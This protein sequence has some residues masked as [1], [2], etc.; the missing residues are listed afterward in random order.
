M[1]SPPFF[2]PLVYSRATSSERFF[3]CICQ[4]VL[5][6]KES[7]SWLI[8]SSSWT[9]NLGCT[10]PGYILEIQHSCWLKLLDLHRPRLKAYRRFRYPG[11]KRCYTFSIVGKTI[12][13][14]SLQIELTSRCRSQRALGMI[15]G[16]MIHTS[17]VTADSPYSII[18]WCNSCIRK[19]IR[20]CIDKVFCA[21]FKVADSF[22]WS[23]YVSSLSIVK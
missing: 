8:G 9:C 3:R 14:R 17:T 10:Y 11:T 7:R 12:L 15:A 23:S 13:E 21:W 6:A 18:S 4:V 5:T 1:A 2:L 20:D 19:V 22:Y 16:C